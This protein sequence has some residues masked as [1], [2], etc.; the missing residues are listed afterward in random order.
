MVR[1]KSD[2]VGDARSVLEP[3]MDD[4]FPG[5][6]VT[7]NTGGKLGAGSAEL[8]IRLEN[9]EARAVVTFEA[10][11]HARNDPDRL[12]KALQQI[13]DQLKEPGDLPAYLITSRGLDTEANDKE[14]EHL[15]TIA[16]VIE[17]DILAERFFSMSIK[18]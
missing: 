15:S 5:G 18:K 4:V 16:H 11:E 12:R 1:L 9:R 13:A 6:D 8:L 10:W 7:L 2:E 14:T 17:A 3:L